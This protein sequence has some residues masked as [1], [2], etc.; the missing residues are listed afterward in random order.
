MDKLKEIIENSYTKK[1]I[2]NREWRKGKP[3]VFSPSSIGMCTRAI[4]YGMLGYEKELPEPR[5][6][7]IMANGTSFHDRFEKSLDQ[8]G[9][10]IAK[11]LSFEMPELMVRGRSDA[12]IKNVYEHE[13]SDKI[14]QLH[15]TKGNLVYEGPDSEV[16]VSELKSANV[17]TFEY[18]AGN[19]KPK[20]EHIQQLSLYMHALQIPN[21]VIIYENKNTQELYMHQVSLDEKVVEFVLNKIKTVV[22]FYKAKELPNKEFMRTSYACTYCDF[23]KYCWAETRQLTLDEIL[24]GL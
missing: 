6:L 1:E 16:I 21:G 18:V 23:A 7:M 17:K 10:L 11:E 24:E 8:A 5:G 13:V 15:D 14:I 4:V 12:I 3:P 20:E 19:R 22:E 2:G 9:V